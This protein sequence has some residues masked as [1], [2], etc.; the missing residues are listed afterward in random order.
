M[1]LLRVPAIQ[2][3]VRAATAA[4]L[5]FWVATLLGA[6]YAIYALVSAVIV[7]DLSPA[8]TRRLATQRMAGT[9][10]GAVAGA[11]FTHVLSSGPIALGFAILASMLCAYA[12]RFEPPAARVAGY[13]AAIAMFAHSDDIWMYAFNRAWETIVGIGAALLVGLVPLWLGADEAQ[14]GG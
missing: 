12:C 13:V 4:A 1:P 11:G 10:I 6:H 7:T 8:T 2:I 9:V 14:R 5:A 3:S